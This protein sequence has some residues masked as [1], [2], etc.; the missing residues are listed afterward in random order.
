MMV[1]KKKGRPTY[2]L[3][4]K[5]QKCGKIFKS[6]RYTKYCTTDCSQAANKQKAGFRYQQLRRALLREQGKLL[7]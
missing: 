3:K 4:L 7:D 1:K 5:C 6:M 2:L